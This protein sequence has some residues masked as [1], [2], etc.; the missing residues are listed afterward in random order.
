MTKGMEDAMQEAMQDIARITRGYLR[1]VPRQGLRL[2]GL[3]VNAVERMASAAL[4]V[5]L[6]VYGL[7][8]RGRWRAPLAAAGGALVE[9]GFSGRCAIYSALRLSSA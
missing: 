1:R 3:N 5:L 4:G 9:R 6:I 7:R 2:E 8:R